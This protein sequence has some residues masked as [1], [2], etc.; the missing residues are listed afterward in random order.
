MSLGESKQVVHCSRAW[1]DLRPQYD[2]LHD[3]LEKIV[4]RG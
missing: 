4:D 2:E 1:S 3:E